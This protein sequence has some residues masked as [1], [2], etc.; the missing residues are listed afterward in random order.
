MQK[1]VE[2]FQL[3]IKCVSEVQNRKSASS[4]FSFSQ[5]IHKSKVKSIKIK[6][7]RPT[8]HPAQFLTFC[9]VERDVYAGLDLRTLIQ[10]GCEAVMHIKFD[11]QV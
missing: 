4:C 9:R 6:T 5:D 11:I 8:N 2:I 10:G 1:L 3:M 7:N